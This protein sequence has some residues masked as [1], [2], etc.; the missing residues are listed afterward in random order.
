MTATAEPTPHADAVEWASHWAQRW[1]TDADGSDRFAIG[2]IQ[3]GWATHVEAFL[4]LYDVAKEQLGDQPARGAA[5]V[6]AWIKRR[7]MDRAVRTTLLRRPGS[8]PAPEG[9]LA[10][11]VEI[12]T[13]SMC[14]PAAFVAVAAND[15]WMI[16]TADP[17]VPAR[18]R[19]HGLSAT[20]LAVSWREER[21]AVSRAR[22]ILQPAWQDLRSEPP[23]MPLANVDLAPAALRAL[24]PL[25]QR[26][27]PYLV[28]ESLA[29]SRF[30]D[31]RRPRTVAIA[32]DQH[33]VGRL[34]VAECGH[35]GIRT[36]VL[37]HGLPQASIGYVPV[38]GDVVAAWSEASRRWFIDHGANPQAVVVTGNPRADSSRTV[39]LPSGERPHVLLALSPTGPA[40][41][42][43][44]VA[45]VL[46]AMTRVQGAKLTIKLHPGQGDWSFVEPIVR[47]HR[48]ATDVTIRQHE[49]LGPMLIDASVVVIHRSSV[50]LDSL[51]ANRPVIVAGV[52]ADL[53]SA[54]LELQE[55]RLPVADGADAMGHA[56]RQLGNPEY[57][58]AYF[59][60]REPVL[61]RHLGPVGGSAARI[62]GLMRQLAT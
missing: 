9:E 45:T 56:I 50:A 3:A 62:V 54:D 59:A 20:R 58:R 38:V 40:T 13:P 39:S 44:V 11:I 26:S 22:Q 28:V 52:G 12:P 51:S 14:D 23:D 55:L 47:R 10:A 30:L 24:A 60:E 21:R 41:N 36:V 49:P 35:R 15:P 42:R 8:G 34:T 46:D 57:V 25:V 32:S 48:A 16:A 27:M 7:G 5:S 37:Q 33:R 4:L 19:S 31:R 29:I 43:E 61:H 53:S 18:L 2:E 17:R 1:F 6:R